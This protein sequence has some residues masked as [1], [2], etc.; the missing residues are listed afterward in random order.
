MI[1]DY[2]NLH[3]WKVSVKTAIRIQQNLSKEITLNYNLSKIQRIAGVDVAFSNEEAVCAVCVFD[4]PELNLIE[5]IKAKAKIT[6]PYI[7]G[8]L[9]FRE[10][11]AVLSAFRRLRNRPDV[12][13]FDGQG[14]CHPRR[15][16]IAAHLGIILDIPSIG[17]AKSHLCG[18]YQMPKDNKGSFSYIYEKGTGDILGAVLRTRKQVKPLFVSCGYKISLKQA[19]KIVLGLCPKY[20]IPQPL[21]YAHQLAGNAR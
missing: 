21:R 2:L 17:C 16:G 9:T 20:R 19:I 15:M 18:V 12:I 8:L 3:P 7:P 13:L 4:F 6:F 5:V 14:I 10:G 11:P 1:M